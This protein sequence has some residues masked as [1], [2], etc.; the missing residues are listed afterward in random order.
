MAG[1]GLGRV[2]F[3]WARQAPSNE[4]ERTNN[5]G[6]VPTVEARVPASHGTCSVCGK[7]QWPNKR[8]ARSVIRAMVRNGTPRVDVNGSPLR[9]Y[10]ACD[11]QGYHVGHKK[12]HY[13]PNHN[14][15]RL[16]F[17]D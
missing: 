3:G 4:Q 5:E 7:Q 8:D 11:E 2:R 16:R 12:A 6:V 15:V 14:D 1:L 10:R 17:V 9:P 13:R